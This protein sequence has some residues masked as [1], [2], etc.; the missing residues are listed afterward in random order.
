MMF[1]DTSYKD[2]YSVFSLSPSQT[3]TLDS[4]YGSI[5]NGLDGSKGMQV[6]ASILPEGNGYLM[7]DILET[8]TNGLD[9]L[10]GAVEI[11]KQQITPT[12][13]TY[14][15]FKGTWQKDIRDFY[16]KV[17]MCNSAS[18]GINDNVKHH[19]F[20]VMTISSDTPTYVTTSYGK[21]VINTSNIDMSLFLSSRT[22]SRAFTS[23][24]LSFSTNYLL[25]TIYNPISQGL[26]SMNIEISDNGIRSTY[27]FSN[28]YLV[29]PNN[30]S[31]YRALDRSMRESQ[32]RGYKPRI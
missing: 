24:S 27:N 1:E 12:W 28:N 4:V 20:D 6:V 17:A 14:R 10:N 25:D 22:F 7:C 31:L 5:A 21:K 2:K 26:D 29:I 8:L 23:R 13:T 15:N 9:F 16:N 11:L 30:N 3:T 18:A 32:R 19:L